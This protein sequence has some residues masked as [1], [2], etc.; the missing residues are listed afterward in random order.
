DTNISELKSLLKIIIVF[1]GI[2]YFFVGMKKLPDPLWR[3]G[4]ALQF[5]LDWNG[6][7]R[8]NFLTQFISG[9]PWLARIMSYGTLVFE[10]SF[11][12]LV[13]TPLRPLCIVAGLM[14]HCGILLTMDVGTL[15][16]AL[17]VW[18]ALL[19]D[20]RTRRQCSNILRK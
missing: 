18:Y 6:V 7:A 12:F 3:Q 8:D 19:F 5:I 15:S 11:I 1:F 16:L 13:F 9:T 20:E 10:M 14:L 17:M 4:A 2:Y